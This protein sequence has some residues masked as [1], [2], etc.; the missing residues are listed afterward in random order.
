LDAIHLAILKEHPAVASPERANARAVA[1]PPVV[2]GKLL[3]VSTGMVPM[4]TRQ[5][6]P[7]AT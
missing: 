5:Q 4:R 7:R 1:E 6:A 3:R 2:P